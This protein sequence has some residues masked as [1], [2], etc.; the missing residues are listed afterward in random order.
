[1]RFYT[2][3]KGVEPLGLPV[4]RVTTTLSVISTN[5]PRPDWDVS[6]RLILTLF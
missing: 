1:M 3:K 5:G 6:V 4:L 2:N